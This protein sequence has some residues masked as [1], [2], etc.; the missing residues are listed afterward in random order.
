[1]ASPTQLIEAVA[2]ALNVPKVTIFQHDRFLVTA[3]YR[4]VAGRACREGD[5][6]GRFGSAHRGRSESDF[7]PN[8]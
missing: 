4:K 8:G 7:W 6:A 1:M 3:G 2:K 5:A